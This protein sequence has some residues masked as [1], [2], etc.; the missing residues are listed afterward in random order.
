MVSDRLGA[1]ALCVLLASCGKYGGSPIVW[2][3]DVE[4]ALAEAKREHRVAVLVF[5]ARWAEGN[6]SRRETGF[7]DPR[8]REDIARGAMPIFVDASEEDDREYA[9][10][11][12]THQ[13]VGIPTTIVFD[14]NG[15]EEARFA[16]YIEPSLPGI[17]AA[18][19]SARTR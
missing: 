11:Q 18:I 8:F 5:C 19:E 6:C 7:G 12:R 3:T 10:L 4:A 2:R 17:A 1:L 13:V 15:R 16:T 9:P 14:R